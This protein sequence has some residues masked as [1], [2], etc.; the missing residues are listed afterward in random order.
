MSPLDHAALGLAALATPAPD[1][2]LDD[3][4]K[5]AE[6]ALDDAEDDE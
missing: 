5:Q 3:L 6:A 1:A 2:S 4:V